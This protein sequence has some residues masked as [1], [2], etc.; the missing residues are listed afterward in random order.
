MKRKIEVVK[1]G[2]IYTSDYSELAW[3]EVRAGNVELELQ[4]EGRIKFVS[5]DGG[6]VL[7][8]RKYVVI[9]DK[10]MRPSKALSSPLPEEVKAVIIAFANTPMVDAN[11]FFRFVQL[12][13]A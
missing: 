7:V 6:Y 12:L 3:A 11:D 9:G 8:G 1:T 5:L 10:K 2:H 4:L 13:L